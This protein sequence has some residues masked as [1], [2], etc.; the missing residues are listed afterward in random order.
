MCRPVCVCVSCRF[1][2]GEQVLYR[3]VLWVRMRVAGLASGVTGQRVHFLFD[4]CESNPDNCPFRGITNTRRRPDVPANTDR[5]NVVFFFAVDT[6]EVSVIVYASSRCTAAAAQFN[7]NL[8]FCNYCLPVNYVRAGLLH[9]LWHFRYNCFQ[10]GLTNMRCQS[11]ITLQ[12]AIAVMF[13]CH[14]PT[15]D[16]INVRA[17]WCHDISQHTHTRT[18]FFFSFFCCCCC[19]CKLKLC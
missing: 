2:L 8:F 11:I 10:N 9:I 19:Y 3:T 15:C 18:Q 7:G 4:V 14:P 5:R 16:L 6:I 13:A 17:R 1:R 12:P